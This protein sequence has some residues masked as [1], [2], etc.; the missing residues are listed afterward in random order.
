MSKK[1]KLEL[2]WI[3]KEEPPRLEPRV[4]VEDSAK[5]A[6]LADAGARNPQF[7]EQE[8]DR[9]ADDLKEGVERELKELE[10]AIRAAKKKARAATTLERKLAGQKEVKELERKL[11]EK[12]KR[13]DAA[14][15]EIEERKDRLIEE[16]EAR[17]QQQAETRELF[18]I[19]WR[20]V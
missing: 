4:S 8:I 11:K 19:W 5:S 12:R 10:V 16:V 7:F 15:D 14:Q 13:R 17:L 9:W 3:G 2:T 1:P 20:V 18:T 6:L